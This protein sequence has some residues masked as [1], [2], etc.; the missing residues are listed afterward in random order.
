M[1]IKE[2]AGH[3]LDPLPGRL[4]LNQGS[5]LLILLEC[6]PLW[7]L[8]GAVMVSTSPATQTP[9]RDQL[10]SSDHDE[11]E[12]TS[13]Q[14]II[15]RPNTHRQE[16]RSCPALVK[17]SLQVSHQLTFLDPA[18]GTHPLTLPPPAASLSDRQ[19]I[20]VWGVLRAESDWLLPA[21]LSF[22][23]TSSL[24][25]HSCAFMRTKLTPDA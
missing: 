3:R 19:R 8:D 1:T 25:S 16:L 9:S 15:D 14:E 4:E 13:S 22:T 23:L 2:W 10:P 11:L 5:F 18:T 6:F 24:R 12:F 7:L 17:Q 21:L 20:A